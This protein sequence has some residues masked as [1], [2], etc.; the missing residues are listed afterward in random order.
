MTSFRKEV[1]ATEM[2]PRE[3]KRDRPNTILTWEL[4]IIIL[5]SKRKIEIN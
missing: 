5:V 3:L 1:L 2:L 4:D